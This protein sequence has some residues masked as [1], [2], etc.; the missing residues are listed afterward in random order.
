[1]A[2][3]TASFQLISKCTNVIIFYNGLK[4]SVINALVPVFLSWNLTE[5]VDQ[6]GSISDEILSYLEGLIES[7]I[8]SQIEM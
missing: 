2:T 1:M 6:A 7:E 5:L 4:P 3:K 8:V